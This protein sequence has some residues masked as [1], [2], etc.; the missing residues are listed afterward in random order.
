MANG[1][2]AG[3]SIGVGFGWN[4]TL[5]NWN[6]LCLFDCLSCRQDLVQFFLVHFVRILN[7][8]SLHEQ[9]LGDGVA[10]K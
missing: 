3:V 6:S 7:L 5:P 4:N 2:C 10:Q 8:I 1:G 9:Y